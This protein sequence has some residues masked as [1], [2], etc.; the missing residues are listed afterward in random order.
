MPGLE[1]PATLYADMGGSLMASE[2]VLQAALRKHERYA[3]G[4]DPHPEGLYLEVALSDAAAYLALPRRWGLTQP[5]GVGRRRACRLPRL[6]LQGRPGR[7]GG[8]GAAFRGGA[9]RGG[10]A[11]PAG[12]CERDVRAGTHAAI[13]AS[14]RRARATSWRRWRVEQDLPLHTMDLTGPERSRRRES[15]A[16]PMR[17]AVMRAAYRRPSARLRAWTGLTASCAAAG[18]CAASA[19][20]PVLAAAPGVEFLRRA[21]S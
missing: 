9:V 18:R 2:A 8:A 10:R 17:R 13:A 11:W 4:G 16:A 6:S 12:D 19:R 14:S 15:A 20:G 5:A 7:G 21:L 1:L 3:G